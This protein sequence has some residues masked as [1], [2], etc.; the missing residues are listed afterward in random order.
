MVFINEKCKHPKTA[1][2]HFTKLIM[3]FMKFISIKGGQFF[4]KSRSHLKITCFRKVTWS[5]LHT[6]NP[7]IIRCHCKKICHLDNPESVTF[8]LKSSVQQLC[9]TNDL[10][11]Q[12]IYPNSDTNTEGTDKGH[13]L[14][15]KWRA[16]LKKKLN[17]SGYKLHLCYK[18]LL[19][20]KAK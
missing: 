4:Q 8:K 1:D 17:I 19:W 13:F 3:Q 16:I 7:H 15:K 2:T 6:E 11:F 18:T 14:H 12:A 20:N 5:K 9:V 10:L